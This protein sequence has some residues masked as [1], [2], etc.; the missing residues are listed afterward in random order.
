[1]TFEPLF[2]LWTTV[3]LLAP[4]AALLIWQLW[5]TWRPAKGV[6]RG[7]WR[8]RLDPDPAPADRGPARV[9]RR[10]TRRAGRDDEGGRVGHRRVPGDRHHDELERRG[11]RF[12]EST[13]A[14]RASTRSRRTRSR[15]RPSTAAPATRSSRS[16]TDRSCACPWSPTRRRCRPRSTPSRWSSSTYAGG[17]SISEP[18]ETLL[19]RLK[20]SQAEHPERLRLVFYFGDGEQTRDDPPESMAEAAPVHRR[21]RG[22]RLR[23]R[24]GRADAPEPR[25]R[26][27]ARS[28]CPGCGP[29]PYLLDTTQPGTPIAISRI[30]ED[31]LKTVASEL[32]V[33]YQH[34]T[35]GT[36]PSF[37]DVED[38]MGEEIEVPEVAVAERLYWIP[39]LAA[40]ALLLWD[41]VLAG[42]NVGDLRAARPPRDARAPRA[43]P[44]LREGGALMGWWGRPVRAR[45]RPR[46]EGDARP[47]ATH[48]AALD[49]PRHPARR[50]SPSAPASTSRSRRP[51][52]PA[53]RRATSTAP[54]PGRA[55]A[56]ASI[57]ST[58]TCRTTT[59]APRTPAATCCPRRFPNCRRLWMLRRVPRRPATRAPTS[60]S[61]TCASATATSRS[62]PGTPPSTPTARRRRSGRSSRT[63]S[64]T[65]TSRSARPPRRA[66]RRPRRARTRRSS[67]R[68][69]SSRTRRRPH[70][71]PSQTPDPNATPTPGPS[72]T[73]DPNST[74]TP[75]PSQ[76]PTR[77]ATPTP[78][79][80]RR[81]PRPVAARPT[82]GPVRHA[83]PEP[84]G[85]ARRP[86]RPRRRAPGDPTDPGDEGSETLGE[87]LDQLEQLGEASDRERENGGPKHGL[88]D[89]PW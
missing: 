18:L 86:A 80:T 75:G 35:P 33:G 76:S 44:P 25:L 40:F 20:G 37:P 78:D 66:R 13:T 42:R 43:R 5:R 7:T 6:A 89:K 15:S 45:G 77:Y 81:R 22:L 73:P 62:A 47:P 63:T 39:V 84:L 11:R 56:S 31:A 30:D 1:M 8:T 64:A 59:S 69:R 60:R 48:A 82:P 29:A 58:S 27:A 55:P 14:P 83:H 61:R 32:G 87:K 10:R 65:R 38:R 26:R 50:A 34:R 72:Q 79:R 9:R 24:G 46:R 36:E 68:S 16:T 49:D 52:A 12:P 17:S 2:E 71:G 41:L 57:R 4:P 21:R 88:A 85:R 70:A 28:R 54:P 23:H 53:S 3:V 74:P 19:K 67:S 51:C